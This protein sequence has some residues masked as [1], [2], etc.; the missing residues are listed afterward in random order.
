MKFWIACVVLGLAAQQAFAE[1]LF[2]DSQL[3]ENEARFLFM[4]TS[5]TAAGLTLLGALILLGV[6]AYL[7]YAGGILGG[8]TG[9]NRNGFEQY[10]NDQYANY[11]QQ[12]AQYSSAQTSDQLLFED[13][14]QFQLSARTLADFNATSVLYGIAV[15]AV[16]VLIV[17]VGLYFYDYYGNT[18]RTEP[19]PDRDYAQYYQ[20]QN[21]NSERAYPALRYVSVIAKYCYCSRTVHAWVKIGSKEG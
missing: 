16:L 8:S 5:G 19:I 17:G 1:E 4:N 14:T 20:Q 13:V 12:Y 15:G 2:D 18:S 9:Y 11:E 21:Q 10:N 6:I 7:I 3:A